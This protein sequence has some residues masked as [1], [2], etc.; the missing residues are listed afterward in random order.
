LIE[1]ART[2]NAALTGKFVMDNMLEWPVTN[3]RAAPLEKAF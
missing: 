3:T 2:I 1:G